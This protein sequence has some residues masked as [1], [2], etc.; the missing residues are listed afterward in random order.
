[1][2]KPQRSLALPLGQEGW[3]VLDAVSVDGDG[4][5]VVNLFREDGRVGHAT[6]LA[7]LLLNKGLVKA[8]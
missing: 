2:S 8:K 3:V 1:M 7:Q 6:E 4:T 5:P